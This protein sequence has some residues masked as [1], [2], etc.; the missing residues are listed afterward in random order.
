MLCECGKCCGL[1]G[2]RLVL[3]CAKGVSL[4]L[5]RGTYGEDE[6]ESKGSVCVRVVG[7]CLP[8]RDSWVLTG[9]R[10]TCAPPPVFARLA[11]RSIAQRLP[12][13]PS[14]DIDLCFC[15]DGWFIFRFGVRE[16]GLVGFHHKGS[17]VKWVWFRH[18]PVM[19]R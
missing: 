8:R 10:P 15:V 14:L 11:T 1:C 13:S 7:E 12:T 18:F 6:R 2:M 4:V 16:G 9:V 3:D 19:Q 17:K 5:C